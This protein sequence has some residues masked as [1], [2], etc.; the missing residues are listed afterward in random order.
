M[1]LTKT[2]P[3]QQ[4]RNAAGTLLRLANHPERPDRKQALHIVA[5]EL[6]LMAER[7]ADDEV[8]P[9]VDGSR[10]D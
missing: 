10:D 2:S 3:E 5:L 9:A 8:D 1:I 6:D 4:L 7:L